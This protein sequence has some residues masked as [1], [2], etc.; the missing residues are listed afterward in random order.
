MR[1]GVELLLGA[2]NDRLVSRPS[3]GCSYD[4]D[5]STILESQVE[6]RSSADDGQSTRRLHR[7]SDES[8]CLSATAQFFFG[9]IQLAGDLK[10]PDPIYLSTLCLQNKVP[11]FEFS[12]ILSNLNRFSKS[13]H[14]RKSYEICYKTQSTMPISP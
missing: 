14:S 7:V 6:R 12:V 8:T 2:D 5:S 1:L 11:T 13:L 9:F 3:R 10:Q 4:A